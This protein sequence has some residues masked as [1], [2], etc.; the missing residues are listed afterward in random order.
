MI[1]CNSI[2][3]K[4]NEYLQFSHRRGSRIFFHSINVPIYNKEGDGFIT[5]FFRIREKSKRSKELGVA[6]ITSGS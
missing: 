5:I 1:G 3:D 4:S 2:P 6:R